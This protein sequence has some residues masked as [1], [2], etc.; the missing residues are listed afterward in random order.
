MWS[1]T[2]I[3]CE[4]GLS[5]PLP[6]AGAAGRGSDHRQGGAGEQSLRGDLEPETGSKWKLSR[7]PH[8][9]WTSGGQTSGDWGDDGHNSWL[10]ALEE[11]KP[12]ELGP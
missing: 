8:I 5:L 11:E 6:G 10:E 9:P 1:H 12:P 7:L 2:G 4:W 3:I